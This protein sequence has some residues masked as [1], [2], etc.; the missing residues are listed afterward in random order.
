MEWGLGR[1]S[2]DVDLGQDRSAGGMDWGLGFAVALDGGLE[3]SSP[4]ASACGQQLE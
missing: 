3:D 4:F 1:L 2:G